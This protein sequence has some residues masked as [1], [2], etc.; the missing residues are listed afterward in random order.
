MS[1]ALLLSLCLP[2]FIVPL[3]IQPGMTDSQVGA[4]LGN[5]SSAILSDSYYSKVIDGEKV[6]VIELSKM[7]FYR[8]W[9]VWVSFNGWDNSKAKKVS[10]WF[11]PKE[12][13]EKESKS[14]PK[15]PAMPLPFQEDRPKTNSPPLSLASIPSPQPPPVRINAQYRVRIILVSSNRCCGRGSFKGIRCLN[16]K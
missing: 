11:E 8:E 3:A 12:P 1:S 10:R 6:T 13:E 2:K 16:W 15:V 7:Q 9:G 14:G 5:P 4:I